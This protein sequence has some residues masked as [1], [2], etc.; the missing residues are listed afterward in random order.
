MAKSV[1]DGIGN[2]AVLFHGGEAWQHLGG[3]IK[4]QSNSS[5]S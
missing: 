3:Y 5:W 4:T 2:N 1:H